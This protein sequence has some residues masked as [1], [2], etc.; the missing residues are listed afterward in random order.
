MKPCIAIGIFQPPDVR[1]ILKAYEG[2]NIP[3]EY[4]KKEGESK[5]LAL[6]EWERGAGRRV[7]GGVGGLSGLF[8]GVSGAQPK[9]SQPLTYLETKRAQAQRIYEEEQKYW[10]DNAEDFKKLIEEDKAK[11][12]AE[13][14]GSLLGYMTGGAAGKPA[15]GAK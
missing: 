3:V 10:R 5:R 12:L 6:E 1:P 2:K 14:K 9:P 13:M 7:G 4:A 15:E 11:Q 8:G